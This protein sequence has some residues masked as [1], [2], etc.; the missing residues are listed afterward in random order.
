MWTRAGRWF[1]GA[2]F[3][4]AFAASVLLLSGCGDSPVSPVIGDDPVGALQEVEQE[5][6][7]LLAHDSDGASPKLL[8]NLL[9]NVLFALESLLI[10]DD[11]G[12]LSLELGDKTATFAVPEGALDKSELI[13]MKAVQAP[14][15]MGE[16]TVFDFGPD[17]LE[18][19]SPATLSLETARAEGSVLRLYWWNNSVGRWELQE[20]CEVRNGVVH[21]SV[22]HF[23]K[24]G[25]S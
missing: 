7:E 14:T 19:S 16:A 13:V 25:I 10:G 8:G 24:Y 4:I 18:F 3:L 21:F 11:G 1:V 9:R 2:T 6:A 20:S 17:G 23:S 12:L 5:H 15:P 22:H